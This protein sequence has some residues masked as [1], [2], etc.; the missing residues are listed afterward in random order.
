[1][2]E[3]EQKR[4]LVEGRD[5]LHSVVHLLKPHIG[6]NQGSEPVQITDCEGESLLGDELIPLWFKEPNTEIL[7]IMLD[8]DGNC[9][10]RWQRVRNLCTPYVEDL[11]EDLPSGGLTVSTIRGRRFGVWIMPNNQHPGMLETF[12]K[13]LVPDRYRQTLSYAEATSKC[14][15]ADHGAPYGDT[16]YDK[17]VMHTWLAWMEPP[18]KPFGTAFAIGILNADAATAGPFLS[19]FRGLYE[20]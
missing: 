17:A 20:I 16:H 14:A 5:D 18:G 19:W 10:G 4:L 8:A 3:P 7:G 2:A 13:E 15:K 1:M 12:L 9:A 11:P 6:W